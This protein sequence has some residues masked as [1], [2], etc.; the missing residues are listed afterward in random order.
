MF[1]EAD[2]SVNTAARL[3]GMYDLLSEGT[4][5]TKKEMAEKFNV[6]ERS[7]QRYFA[8][9]RNFLEERN[10][11]YGIEQQLLYDRT[12]SCYRLEPSTRYVLNNAEIFAVLKILLGSRALIK[13]EMQRLLDKLILCCLPDKDRNLMNSL[14][15]NEKLNFVEPYHKSQLIDKL[16]QLAI[17]LKKQKLVKFVYCKNNNE[18]ISREV[19]PVGLMCSEMYFYLIAY[20]EQQDNK[21]YEPI[22]YRIDRMTEVIK[23]ENCFSIPYEYR[24]QEGEFRKRIQYMY[25]GTLQK[26]I[27]HCD[28]NSLEAVM[29]RLPTSKIIS[30]DG[31]IYTIRAEVLGKKGLDIWLNGQ[32]D[33]NLEIKQ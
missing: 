22:I 17:A 21:A 13:S 4:P 31:S 8:L 2:K 3:L 7:I 33:I 5:F 18:L 20:K 19:M 26:V 24:F 28:E 30:K 15:G 11:R 12:T 6:N 25:G 1:D 29:D 10:M 9:L 32:K 23:T 27:L 16:W 14:I